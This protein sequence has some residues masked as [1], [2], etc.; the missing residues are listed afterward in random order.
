M[1]SRIVFIVFCMYKVHIFWEYMNFNFGLMLQKLL[2]MS[3]ITQGRS[4]NYQIKDNILS[5]ECICIYPRFSFCNHFIVF[6][7]GALISESFST[8]QK[9]C[10]IAILNLILGPF[11]YYVS[12]FGGKMLTWAKNIRGKKLFFACAER[13]VKVNFNRISAHHQYQNLLK[14]M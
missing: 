1:L 7:K 3:S 11:K 2:S 10:Q 9:M 5:F 13:K 8:L 6:L 14:I 12:K 4:N